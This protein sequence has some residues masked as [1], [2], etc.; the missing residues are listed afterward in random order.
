[1]LKLA[2]WKANSLTQHAEELKMFI[3]T[4]N[5]DVIPISETHFTEK[6]YLKIPKYSTQTI[7]QV[8]PKKEL[9]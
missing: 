7:Q 2:K 9:L 6:S 3:S 4:H 1:M 8:L 5:T